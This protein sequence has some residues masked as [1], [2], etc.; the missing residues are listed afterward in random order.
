[1]L[2]LRKLYL[3]FILI[4]G[5][6]TATFKMKSRPFINPEQSLRF[7]VDCKCIDKNKRVFGL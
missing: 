5:M 4:A 3:F 2:R 6:E 7:V 1:M